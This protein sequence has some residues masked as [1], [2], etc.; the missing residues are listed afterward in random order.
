MS[1]GYQRGVKGYRLWCVEEGKQK[2]VIKRDVTFVEHI[3]PYLEKLDE[4]KDKDPTQVEVESVD[5]F[6]E[7]IA[8]TNSQ[9]DSVPVDSG[10]DTD[11]DTTQGD[12]LSDY[13]L[14][15]DRTRRVNRRP[16]SRY[17][18]ADIISYVLC[19]AKKLECSEPASCSQQ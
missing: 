2:V 13:Q 19:T 4:E 18:E 3:M 10:S 9:S 1:L 16:P 8:A 11:E 17:A 12:D 15:R 6:R 5:K 7:P 14:A